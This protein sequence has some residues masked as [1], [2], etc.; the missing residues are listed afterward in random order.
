MRPSQ[1]EILTC[2]M[3]TACLTSRPNP[4]FSHLG[5]DAELDLSAEVARRGQQR[6]H[7]NSCVAVGV[8][9]QRQ[10]HLEPDLSARDVDQ[11]V[12]PSSRNLS[13]AVLS[14]VECDRL[15]GCDTLLCNTVQL[16]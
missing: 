13:L 8:L 11:L 7:Q 4:R 6:R 9:P 15:C 1:S 5:D 2:E 16:N 10:E 14:A 12:Q 3:A